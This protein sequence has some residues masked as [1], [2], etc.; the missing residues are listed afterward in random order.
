MILCPECA[1]FSIDDCVAS[2]L[3][4]PIQFS[5]RTVNTKD[6]FHLFT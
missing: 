6:Q 4:R 5:T 2:A 1:I 3:D